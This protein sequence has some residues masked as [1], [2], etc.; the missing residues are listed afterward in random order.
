MQFGLGEMTCDVQEDT[1]DYAEGMY[2]DVRGM[3]KVYTAF[4]L[5]WTSIG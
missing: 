2:S 1:F 5:N 4:E 3:N